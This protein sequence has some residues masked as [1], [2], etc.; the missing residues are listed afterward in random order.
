MGGLKISPAAEVQKQDGSVIP[1]LFAA[2][3]VT[4]GVHGNNRLGGSSLQDCVVYGR[5]AGASAARYLLRTNL[6]EIAA[7]GGAT[8]R[9]H[10]PQCSLFTDMTASFQAALLASLA[11]CR[12]TSSSP[13]TAASPLRSSSTALARPALP[14]PPPLLPPLR[15]PRLRP[16]RRR[17]LPPRRRRRLSS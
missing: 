16:L 1:G 12:P 5:V 7:G 3:E 4:G 13:A 2:G 10:Y 17:P 9:R 8:G 15:L 6:E 14:L 11:S